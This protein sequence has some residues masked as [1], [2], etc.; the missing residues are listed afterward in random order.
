MDFSK[1]LLDFRARN[2]LTQ[3]EASKVIG[4]SINMIHRYE[5]KTNKPT[6]KNKIIFE[7]KMKEWEEKN[8]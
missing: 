4:V 2:N 8:A 6:A 7:N 1:I 3:L 5:S